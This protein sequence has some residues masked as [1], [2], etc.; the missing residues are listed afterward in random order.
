MHSEAVYDVDRGRYP[1]AATPWDQEEWRTAALGWATGALGARG[2]RVTGSRQ[3]RLRPW[4]VLVR[5]SADGAGAVWFK[6]N[7]PASAFEAGLAEALARWAPEHV[8]RPLAV[9]AE[10]GG[11]LLPDGGAR[12]PGGLGG[13]P[14][15]PPPV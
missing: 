8:L 4:S 13:G 3:V 10:R 1:D 12:R 6:A 9:D 14:G 5:L 7:P 2:L 11:A 15:G